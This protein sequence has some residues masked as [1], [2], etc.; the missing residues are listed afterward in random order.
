M[1]LLHTTSLQVEEFPDSVRRKYAILSHTWGQNEVSFE[2]MARHRRATFTTS[3]IGFKKIKRCC[4]VARRHGFEHVWIDTCCIDKRNSAELSEA[5][6]S[7]YR[8]YE[9]ADVCFIYLA[10]VRPTPDRIELL[11]RIQRSKWNSRG[12]TLQEL[13][14][15]SKRRFLAGDWSEIQDQEE[16]IGAMSTRTGI[17][18]RVLDDRRLISTVCLAER[19]SWVSRRHTSRPEDLAYC[20]LGIFN[21]SMPILYGEGLQKAFW[22]LQMEIMQASFDQ[23]LFAWRAPYAGSGLLANS[24]HVFQDTPPLRLW[25]P[26]YLTPYTMTNVG[27]TVRVIDITQKVFGGKTPAD[28]SFLALIQCEGK[29]NGAWMGLAVYLQPGLETNEELVVG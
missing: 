25:S 29:L 14:A 28:G 26:G 13:L 9:N 5:L 24:P 3:K 16:L 22:R 17:A 11:A 20:L 10:D 4:D 27:L 2:E 18:Q 1:R 7:M 12:W 8:Y 6:N 21:I 19:M 15:S 23:T